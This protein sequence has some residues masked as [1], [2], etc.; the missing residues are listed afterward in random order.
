MIN[1]GNCKN[2][3]KQF[4]DFIQEHEDIAIEGKEEQERHYCPYY[5]KIYEGI[6]NI[7]WNN[8][9]KCPFFAPNRSD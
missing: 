6:P 2:Y 9:E 8:K 4:D 3:N 1:C 5:D 7:I